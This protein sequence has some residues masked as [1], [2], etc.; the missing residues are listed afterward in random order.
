MGEIAK[1]SVALH[2][3]V[4]KD[5]VPKDMYEQYLQII[6]QHEFNLTEQSTIDLALLIFLINIGDIT[7]DKVY[8]QFQIFARLARACF[9][10]HGE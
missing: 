4:K 9:Y 5:S 6:K 1:G 2:A 8:E 7:F 3:R 10:D